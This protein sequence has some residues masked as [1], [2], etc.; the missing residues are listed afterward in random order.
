MKT[1][2]VGAEYL[3]TETKRL[4]FQTNTDTCALGPMLLIIFSIEEIVL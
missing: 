2:R 4:R 3:N 1:L